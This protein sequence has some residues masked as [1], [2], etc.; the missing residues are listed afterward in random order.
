MVL[1]G[2]GGEGF[3]AGICVDKRP[4]SLEDRKV[5]SRFYTGTLRLGRTEPP[6]TWGVVVVSQSLDPTPTGGDPVDAAR[7][8]GGIVDS[9]NVVATGECACTVLFDDTFDVA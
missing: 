7:R 8:L 1:T 9:S 2:G 4:I 5:Q 3:L 6:G